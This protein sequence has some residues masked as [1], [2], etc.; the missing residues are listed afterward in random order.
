MKK[1]TVNTTILDRNASAFKDKVVKSSLTMVL[2]VLLKIF[3][4]INTTVCKHKGCFVV[5]WRKFSPV[6]DEG[7]IGSGLP[8]L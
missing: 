5:R 7:R 1:P 8:M 6:A 3:V 2:I 4:E